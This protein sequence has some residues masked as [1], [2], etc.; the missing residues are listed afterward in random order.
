[1]FIYRYLFGKVE[2]LDVFVVD[3]WMIG[4][5][6]HRFTFFLLTKFTFI[7]LGVRGELGHSPVVARPV[8]PSI[9]R[10]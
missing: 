1:M 5:K 4:K 3:L 10:N 9:Q 6:T 7:F 2:E 8:E